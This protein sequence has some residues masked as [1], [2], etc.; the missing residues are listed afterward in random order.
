MQN[1][2]RLA[3]IAVTTMAA[4]AAFT[5]AAAADRAI[6]IEN[7][8]FTATGTIN[9]REGGLGGTISC[10]ITL[11]G[12]LV[13]EIRKV[14]ARR[15]PEGRIGT[16]DRV[17]TANCRF[18]MSDWVVTHLTPIEL[19]YESFTGTLPNITGIL[20]LALRLGLRLDSADGRFR[21]LYRGDVPF[22]FQ[23][24]GTPGRLIQKRYLPN[25][26]T[27]IEGMGTGCVAGAIIELGG[28]L[29]LG[30]PQPI[31]TLL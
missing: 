11:R 18:L 13:T 31:L 6:R 4:L 26:L 10:T 28:T 3:L 27:Q 22:I 30:A 7:G 5:G 29:A 2:T 12:R 20:V 16:I 25:T 19:R 9:I 23:S 8:A 24:G 21:C 15:L 17:E 1:R 14:N